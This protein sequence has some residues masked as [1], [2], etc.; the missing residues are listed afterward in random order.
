MTKPLFD[1]DGLLPSWPEGHQVLTPNRRLARQIS[2]AWADHCQAQHKRVWEQPAIHSLDV[3]LENNWLEL[4]DRGHQ[5]C[6]Q[7]TVISTLEEQFLWESVISA[8]ANR[9]AGLSAVDAA[10]LAQATLQLIEAWRLPMHE[11]AATAHE[12]CQHFLRWLAQFQAVLADRQLLTTLTARDAVLRAYL[13]GD[14]PISPG[15]ILVGFHSSPTPLDQQILDA[16]FTKIAHWRQPPSEVKRQIYIAAD[17]SD[18]VRAAANWAKAQLSTQP[19]QRLGL[20]FPNLAGRRHHID[21]V[22]REAFS[23]TYCLPEHAH[24]PPP[25]NITAGIPLAETALINSALNLLK[26]QPMRRPLSFYCALLNDPFWGDAERET[27]AR[28]T[29]QLILRQGSNAYPR[30]GDFRTALHRAEQNLARDNKAAPE[31][32]RRLQTLADRQRRQPRRA[33]LQYWADE[34]SR[35]LTLLGWPGTRTLNSIEFQQLQIWEEVLQTVVKLDNAVNTVDLDAAIRA[36]VTACR[37]RVF[38]PQGD[39]FPVQIMGV[40]EAAGL[41]FDQL[42]LAE[43]HDNQWPQRV[44]FNPLLS[45]SLQRQYQLPK[46]SPEHELELAKS[47]LDD[48]AGGSAAVVYSFGAQDGDSERQLTA[49]LNAKMDT[50]PTPDQTTTIGHLFAQS[51]LSVRLEKIRI[52]RAPALTAQEMVRGG[53]GILR[54]QA[55]CPFNAFAVWRLGAT[56]LP[57]P[58][59]GLSPLDRGNILHECME[60][61]WRQTKDHQTLTEE[62]REDINKLLKEISITVL[63]TYKNN[64]N[65]LNG[66]RF[67]AS[68]VKRLV[69]LCEAWLEIERQRRPFTV[70]A[71]EQQAELQL[72]QLPLALR[73]DRIDVLPDGTALL[74]DYKTGN[75]SVNSLISERPEQPQLL[76]YALT[77]DRPLAG[78]CF[79]QISTDKGLVFKGLSDTPDIAPGL[80]GPGKLGLSEDWSENLT[81]WRQQLDALASEFCQG[82]AEM[83]VYSNTAFAYQ[84]HLSPL[85]RW[86][87][88][89]GQ[90]AALESGSLLD[91]DD[92]S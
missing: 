41:S 18:E 67:F 2:H 75:C 59:P 42:W 48:L 21:R 49:L 14:L 88:A 90:T 64:F 7:K 6:L 15:V 52:D 72:N 27:N 81:R 36:L 63:N 32:G 91:G 70:A 30:D 1:I 74:I 8:D 10:R 86:P 37:N 25:Y 62:P 46:T 60:A 45:V 3:W 54:D 76:L 77:C 84:S 28:A 26:V 11:I 55:A 16:A 58:A 47:L 23:P 82:D 85:N 83:V 29:C 89:V 73:I 56:P 87:E 71:V 53:S 92:I 65:F 19:G 35:W 33:S 4:Q 68:E 61:F 31:L 78:L 40:L 22:F 5:D 69:T 79:A 9:P 17:D 66:E 50:L 24:E 57:E 12:A 20:V 13:G 39:D 44:S 80:S 34:F 38:Q 51:M 43:M